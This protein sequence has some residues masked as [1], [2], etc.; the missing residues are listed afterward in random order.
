MTVQEHF[1]EIRAWLQ[2]NKLKFRGMQAVFQVVLT[3]DEAGPFWLRTDRG[4]FSWGEGNA[5]APAC[6][7]IC[8][9]EDFK[10]LAAGEMSPAMAFMAGKVKIQGNIGVAMKF[11]SMLA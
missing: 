11:G 3:G 4:D 7:V 8:A 2:Q 5:E 10:K 9:S 1:E 6:T